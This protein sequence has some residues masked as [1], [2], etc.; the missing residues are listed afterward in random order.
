MNEFQNDALTVLSTEFVEK[1]KDIPLAAINLPARARTAVEAAGARNSLEAAKIVING[2][3]GLSGL[4]PKTI[5][6]SQSL[7]SHFIRIVETSAVSELQKLIDPRKI[8]FESANGNLIDVFPGILE[9]YLSKKSGENFKRNQDILNKRFALNGGKRYTLEDIGTYYDLTRERIRQV[10]EKTIENISKLLSGN[11]KTKDWKLDQLLLGN[12][13]KLKERLNSAGA[14]ILKH[15][16][17]SI[18]FDIFGGVSKEGYQ[19]LLMEVA[20]YVKLPNSFDGF[21]GTTKPCWCLASTY[22]KTEIESIFKSLDSIFDS[23]AAVSLFEITIRAKKSAKRKISNESLSVALKACNEIEITGDSIS[24]KFSSLRNAADKAFRVL[25]S[26]NKA[27][28]YSDIA[29]EI[30]LL[31]KNLTN[32]KTV[33]EINLKNQLVS[34]SRFAPIGKSGEWGLCS[35]SH[36]NNITIVEAIE[37]VLHKSGQ[38]LSFKTISDETTIIRPNASVKS[39]KVYL[40]DKTNK[41]T[42]VGKDLYA[43]SSWKMMPYKGAIKHNTVSNETFYKAA[44]EILEQTNPI[45]LPVF[46]RAVSDKTELSEISIRQRVVK[47]NYLKT[48]PSEYKYKLVYCTDDFFKV[49]ESVLNR[50]LLR[51]KVQDEIR[52]ILYETPNIPIKKGDLYLAVNKVFPCQR[53][54]FYH[55]LEEAKDIRQFKEGSNYFAV[56]EYHE[57]KK[58]IEVD[59]T[60]YNIDAAM[61]KKL[62]RPFSMLNIE[63]I[64][65]ALFELGLLF[66]N[67]L[68]EYLLKAKHASQFLVTQNDLSKLSKMIDCV[69][70]E[71]I[72]TK[73]HHLNTLR[74]ERNDRAHGTHPTE[75][76]RK[77]LFDKAYYVANL[78][79]KYIAFFNLM[80]LGLS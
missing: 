54:T 19:D 35:W 45:P 48:K 71:K 37:S 56:F 14:I 79:V 27:M 34:D 8:H 11:L 63:D 44:K 30:N 58:R 6:E 32:Y 36:L 18:L 68:K 38:P 53:S 40:S 9:L 69:I 29:K 3:V 49:D 46:I 1:A 17:D 78:F 74:E 52:A 41:F 2:F 23:S 39:I 66:E 57:K 77:I 59:L 76:E 26:A 61:T 21:R 60:P 80:K 33:K 75:E 43:L 73:G 62:E 25:E 4:G 65:I 64:D 5:S 31:D 72:V 67:E 12:Y 70:R 42:R 47:S 55:Y 16:V 15:E 51:D 20:G 10:E 28:H 7:I 13:R 50:K 24:V 22:Q